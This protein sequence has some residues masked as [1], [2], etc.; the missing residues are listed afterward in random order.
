MSSAHETLRAAR[1]ELQLSTDD[2]ERQLALPQGTLAGIEE[3]RTP[4]ETAV[5]DELAAF[6]GLQPADV[7]QGRPIGGVL[8]PVRALLAASSPDLSPSVRSAL[9]RVAAVRR[10]VKRLEWEL[11]KADRY[12]I[13]RVFFKHGVDNGTPGEASLALV[14]KLREHQHLGAD[15]ALPSMRSLCERLGIEFVTADLGDPRVAGFSLADPGHGPAIVLNLR[16]ANADPCVRRW[17]VAHELC[18]VLHDETQHQAPVQLYDASARTPAEA[19]DDA[20]MAADRFAASLLAPDDA[21]RRLFQ[22][23]KAQRLPLPRQVQRLME[24]LGITMA[25]ACRRLREV[26]DVPEAELAALR[27]VT[28]DRE[29]RN[30]WY[31][32]EVTWDD[33]YFPCRSVPE[34]RRG[35]F[36]RLVAE[37][38]GAERLDR[39][40]AISLLCAG[41]DEPLE[42]L[43]ANVER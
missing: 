16:G 28:I 32:A 34:E 1:T 19:R 10:E 23:T 40:Q 24:E 22:H 25:L 31:A 12:T 37:A 43:L 5:A 7:A 42:D 39:R 4:L 26:C 33:V 11:T 41:P 14:K 18:H 30:D 15:D 8:A 13:L 2:V 29:R 38:W 6:Y 35:Y 36:A 9:A 21:V 17:T 27:P 20:V 3:G